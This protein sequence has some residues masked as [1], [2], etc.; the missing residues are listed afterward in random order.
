MGKLYDLIALQF[1]IVLKIN[2]Y[3]IKFIVADIQRKPIF[4]LN[5]RN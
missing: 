2:V 3:G 1:I 4:E 5:S